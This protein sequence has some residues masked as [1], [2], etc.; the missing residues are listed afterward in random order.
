MRI[1]ELLA[2]IEEFAPLSLQEDYDNAGL[3]CGDPEQEVTSV[4]LTTDITETVV[5]EAIA[6]RHDLI[7]S[8]HPLT[9]QGLKHLR[10]E[11]Y[12]QRC[13]IKAIRQGIGIY[14]AHTNMDAARQGVSDRMADKLQ[15][16]RRQI[17]QPIGDAPE[18][19]AGFGI[20]G[21][22]PEAE[23]PETFLRRVKAI[24]QCQAIRHT[25]LCLPAVKRVAL[26]GGAGA[27]L[28]RTAIAQGADIYISADF[29]YHDFFQAE[30]RIII[31]DIGHYESE[32]FTKEIFYE[33]LTK[34]LSNFAVQFSRV[35]TN[36]VYYL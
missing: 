7:V 17:L 33:L 34:K 31:A 19:A 22:L 15:L 21:E 14:S 5:D 35:Q 29:K 27:F 3:I 6:G 8:H 25:A 18:V 4:L 28:T 11:T 16:A 30:N 32:Q 24:F 9:L 23:N 26:C 2:L 36:P 13:L 20:I 12:I 10:P 1:K